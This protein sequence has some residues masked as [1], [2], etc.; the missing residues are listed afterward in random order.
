MGKKGPWIADNRLAELAGWDLDL[1]AIEFSSL[2][3]MDGNTDLNFDL[4]VTGFSFGAI[5]QTIEAAKK[6]DAPDPDDCFEPNFEGPTVS[7]LGDRWLLGEHSILCGDARDST[8]HACAL[9]GLL[10]QAAICDPPYNVKGEGHISGLGKVVHPDFLM[11]SGEMTDAEFTTFLTDFLRATSDSLVPG[12]VLFV[13]MD[14]R[15]V[16]EILDAARSIGLTLLNLCVWNKGTG[17]MGSLYRSQ[18]AFLCSGKA[19]PPIRIGSSSEGMVAVV[20]MSGIIRDSRVSGQIA[21]SS[22]PI[23]PRRKIAP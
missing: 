13:F 16:R 15:H 21:S 9:D 6:S 4:E 18:H 17:G 1:L 2:I 12:A 10:A 19:T 23:I 22:L 20:P 8:V 3:E 14:W 11:A 7:R 5:D